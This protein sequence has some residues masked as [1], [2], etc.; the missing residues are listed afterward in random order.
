[1]ATLN[2]LYSFTPSTA[3]KASEVNT[4][5][6]TVKSFVDAITTGANIDSGAITE[7]KIN[8]GAVSEAKIANNAV[9]T[10][11]INAG[12]V[13]DAKLSLTSASGVIKVYATTTARDAAITTPAAGMVVYINSDDSSEGLWHYNG[14]VWYKGAGWNTPWGRIVH[15]LK[16]TDSSTITSGAVNC[17]TG[18]T[19]TPVV[20]RAYRISTS[21]FTQTTY[22]DITTDAV[23]VSIVDGS[24]TVLQ[25]LSAPQPAFPTSVA[26]IADSFIFIP[27]SATAVT[28]NVRMTISAGTPSVK[29]KGGTGYQNHIVIEDIGAA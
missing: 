27:S 22:N 19:F 21:V 10:D 28:F 13:T 3:A 12:A 6:N 24:N 9:T 11:K 17:F 14:A 20:G 8:N 29:F 7:A 23:N 2:G 16:T 1:M 4:N 5:F 25:Y 18:V 15:E 26:S